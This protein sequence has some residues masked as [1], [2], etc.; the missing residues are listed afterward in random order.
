MRF[1][2]DIYSFFISFLPAELELGLKK[3]ILNSTLAAFIAGFSFAFFSIFFLKLILKTFRTWLKVRKRDRRL[4]SIKVPNGTF[5]GEVTQFLDKLKVAVIRINKKNVR[6]GDTI[7]IKG[8]RTN[9]MLPVKSLQIDR[10]SVQVVKKGSEAGLL[11]GKP[12]FRNDLIF[13]ISK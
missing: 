7:L 13:K 3:L 11:T 10:Q 12:V 4:S 6:V 2:N 9:L 1:L 8:K 5:V